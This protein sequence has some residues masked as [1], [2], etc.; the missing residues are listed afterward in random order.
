MTMALLIQ[1]FEFDFADSDYN[2]VIKK[3][4]TIKPTGFQAVAR[5]RPGLTPTFMQR[6]LLNHN[7]KNLAHPK[8]N[9]ITTIIDDKRETHGLRLETPTKLVDLIICYGSNTG[10]CQTLA[11]T[12]AG[13]APKHG[14]CPAVM[15]MDQATGKITTDVKVPVVVITASY[16]GQPPDNATCFASW[17]TNLETEGKAKS[18][19]GHVHAVYGCGHRDWVN[20]FQKVPTW[21]DNALVACGSHA[22][23]KRGFSDVSYD[24]T[25]NEFD[26]WAD[27]SLWPAL[28]QE[29]FNGHST[30]EGNS[31]RGL[32]KPNAEAKTSGFEVV[33]SSRVQEL[34]YDGREG[35]VLE[36]T[37]LTVPGEPEKRHVKI[38]LPSGME[39]KTGDYLAVL[40]VNHD[41]TVKVAMTRF[42]LAIDAQVVSSKSINC[43]SS[44]P[45]Y[46]S[47]Y[48][49][50]KELVELNHPATDKVSRF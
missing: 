26:L 42:G 33:P 23:V 3:T 8:S 21:V 43:L 30:N 6:R 46:R 17:L 49:M 2:L 20:T 31:E 1:N 19:D 29:Y 25:F 15:S 4:L 45:R 37:L 44:E 47:A 50:L 48:I 40:P 16:E 22:G 32:K 7:I 36:S 12:L 10:T 28:T 13:E 5:L 35:T 18:L 34:D 24:D 41:E 39:Y 38:Q 14:F 27:G 11:H 9:T